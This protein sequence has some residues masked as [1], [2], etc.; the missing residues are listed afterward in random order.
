MH[1]VIST[2][3]AIIV[4]LIAIILALFCLIFASASAISAL[5]GFIPALY[6]IISSLWFEILG[7]CM[8]GLGA[9]LPVFP[10]RIGRGL[11]ADSSPA[12]AG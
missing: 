9:E 2:V 5:V 6:G 1:F 8:G 10:R 7:R 11:L 4:A 3:C 12:I